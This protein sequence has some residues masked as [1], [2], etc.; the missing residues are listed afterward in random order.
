VGGTL[1]QASRCDHLCGREDV[2]RGEGDPVQRPHGFPG[3]QRGVGAAGPGQ[4]G[5]R[6][7]LHERVHPG[8]AF[9]DPLEER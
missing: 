5:L 7:D 3:R 4:R 6:R 2:L 9:L 8:V 1:G